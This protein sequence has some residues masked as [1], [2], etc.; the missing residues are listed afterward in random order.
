MRSRWGG[1]TFLSSNSSRDS[2]FPWLHVASSSPQAATSASVAHPSTSIFGIHCGTRGAT[3]NLPI[4]P[5]HG[6]SAD[7][8]GKARQ[9]KARRGGSATRSASRELLFFSRVPRPPPVV[10]TVR[11][12]ARTWAISASDVESHAFSPAAAEWRAIIPTHS[13]TPYCDCT[14]SRH[15]EAR[16]GPLVSSLA[17]AS[18]AASRLRAVSVDGRGSSRAPQRWRCHFSPAVGRAVRGPLYRRVRLQCTPT[19]GP[20]AFSPPF[21]RHGG[22]RQALTPAA[23]VIS[24]F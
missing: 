3:T 18:R 21:G 8:Q 11:P 20:S 22:C 19:T 5:W 2:R 12:R 10:G 17:A 13:R 4:A 23:R 24:N 9:G 7:E 1:S 15:D 14:C 16:N 6:C